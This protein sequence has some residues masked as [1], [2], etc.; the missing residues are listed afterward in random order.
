M[1]LMTLRRLEVRLLINTMQRGAKGGTRRR[2]EVA[3]GWDKGRQERGGGG[4]RKARERGGEEVGKGET[5][6]EETL[7][8]KVVK[9]SAS[10]AAA[11]Q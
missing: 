10:L 8:G 1:F 2:G 6:A 3:R 4:K 9:P 7:R 11:F 5:S